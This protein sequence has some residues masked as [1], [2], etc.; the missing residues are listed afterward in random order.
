M[1][2][3]D[4]SEELFRGIVRGAVQRYCQK[5][6]QPSLQILRLDLEE[7]F[8]EWHLGYLLSK[9][10]FGE[11]DQFGNFNGYRYRYLHFLAGRPLTSKNTSQRSVCRSAKISKKMTI[12]LTDPL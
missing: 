4:L 1:K 6:C 5:N 11:L 7:P 10:P 3:K 12:P 2:S 9:D 8:A